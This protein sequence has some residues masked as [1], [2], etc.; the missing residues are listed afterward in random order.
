L[1]TFPLSVIFSTFF[2]WTYPKYGYFC[3]SGLFSRRI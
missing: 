3:S 2:Y 1:F